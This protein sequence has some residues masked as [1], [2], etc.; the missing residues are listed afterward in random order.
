MQFGLIK[1]E[2]LLNAINS[3]AGATYSDLNSPTAVALHNGVII[4]LDSGN[5][6]VKTFN[7]RGEKLNEFGQSGSLK[8]Y[9]KYPEVMTIDSHGFI[10]VGDGGNCKVQVRPRQ[11]CDRLLVEVRPISL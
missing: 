9:F 11:F 3:G 5:K 1:S 8:G 4:V 10:L 6:R 7:Q 2:Q